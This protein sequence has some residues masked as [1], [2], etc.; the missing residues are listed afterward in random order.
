LKSE[1]ERVPSSSIW[2]YDEAYLVD[3]SDS[4]MMIMKRETKYSEKIR[5]T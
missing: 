3:D 5:N 4:K 1:L 2:N